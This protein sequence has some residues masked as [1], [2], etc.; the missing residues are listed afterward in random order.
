M[1]GQHRRAGVLREA[2][3]AEGQPLCEALWEPVVD[4]QHLSCV[5]SGE[6]SLSL[7]PQERVEALDGLDGDAVA[8]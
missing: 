7:A 5:E 6:R 8:L 2:R 3:E 1:E 4:A